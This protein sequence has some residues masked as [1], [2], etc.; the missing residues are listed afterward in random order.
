MKRNIRF[1]TAALFC[2]LLIV[3]PAFAED[4]QFA[5]SVYG[6][7]LPF[8]SGSAGSGSGAPDYSDA[9]DGGVGFGVEASYKVCPGFT[10]LGGVGYETFSGKTYKGISFEDLEII[11]VYIGGKIHF[12][13]DSKLSPYARVDVGLAHFSD[14]RVKYAGTKTKYWNESFEFFGDFGGGVEYRVNSFGFFAEVRVR[15]MGAPA[16]DMGKASDADQSWS[17]PIVVGASW[18]F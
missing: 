7:Y 4:E 6:E 15:Y 13:E 3:Q 12:M 1:L 5:V 17:V 18:H 9:F 10:F 11:P 8:I 2:A 16:S 14:V